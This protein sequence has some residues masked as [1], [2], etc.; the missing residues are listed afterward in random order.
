MKLTLNKCGYRD[1][2][3]LL[4]QAQK[5]KSNSSVD[6]AFCVSTYFLSNLSYLYYFTRSHFHILFTFNGLKWWNTQVCFP[7]KSFNIQ[8]RKKYL[9]SC[10]LCK[11]SHFWIITEVYIFDHWC[12][13]TMRQNVEKTIQEIILKYCLMIL[14]LNMV[15]SKY[16]VSYGW[17]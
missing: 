5:L 6:G 4:F 3:S 17:L 2:I 12:T 8:G 14:F 15:G 11:L 1:R 10:Q 7:L 9:V 13:S 16:L